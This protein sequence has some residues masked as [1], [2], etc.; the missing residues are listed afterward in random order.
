MNK[1]KQLLVIILRLLILSPNLFAQ[2]SGTTQAYSFAMQGDIREAISSLEGVD[3]D[4]S[5]E[6]GKLRT[7]MIDR[8]QK[9]EIT[10]YTENAD[11]NLYIDIYQKY[12]QESM[13][14][15]QPQELL[16]SMLRG[17]VVDFLMPEFPEIR[18]KDSEEDIKSF[19]EKF[20]ND[21]GFESNAYGRTSHLMDLFVWKRSEIRRY[22]VGLIEDT[23]EVDVYFMMDPILI[24]WLDYATFGHAHAGGWATREALY[25][26][27]GSYDLNSEDFKISYLCHEGQHFQDYIDY[28]NLRSMDLEYRAKLIEL[29]KLE[30][31]FWRKMER[32]IHNGAPIKEQAHPFANYTLIRQL[33]QEY[34]KEER[35][36][37]MDQWKEVPKERIKESCLRLFD[38][39]TK[40]LNELG[41][42]TVESYI[43]SL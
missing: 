17:Q 12:W 10:R 19:S 26:F 37:D 25:S 24:G 13:M 40:A 4:N 35:M 32:F 31:F 42:Q 43:D 1:T 18:E 5:N 23:V 30:E 11:V 22:R 41:A 34:F 33:S 7:K 15:D 39:H 9:R 6:A 16:D 28:P 3:E 8:F 27:P 21:R 36:T 38:E 29:I 20:L 14:T 2:H